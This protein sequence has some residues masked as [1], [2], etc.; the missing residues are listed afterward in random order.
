MVVADLKGW[1]ETSDFEDDG[2]QM[3]RKVAIECCLPL[4]SGVVSRFVVSLSL[5]LFLVFR[6]RME[7]KGGKGV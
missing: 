1:R 2:N 6:T 4:F 5:G 7:W 3:G